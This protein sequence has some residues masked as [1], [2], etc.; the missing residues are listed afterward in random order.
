MH[1]NKET[2]QAFLASLLQSADIPYK[3]FNDKLL[4]SALPSIGLR[5]PFLRK[6]AKQIGKQHANAFLSVCGMTYH[7]ERLLYGFVCATFPY[8]DFLPHSD[9]FA[10][11][12]VENWAIC[13]TFCNSIAKTI[14]PHKQDYFAHIMQY[15]TSQN[16]WAVR[17][18]L[19]IMLSNYLEQ[20]TISQVLSR[21]CAITSD[22]YYVQMAQAWLLATAWAK[23]PTETNAHIQQSAL[24]IDV[25]QKFVQKARESKRVSKED[26]EN[27][28]A[29]LLH[30]KQQQ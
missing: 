1:W 26:K 4:A 22:F 9:H 15:L 8:A 18:G 30:K 11:H 19:V 25:L 2:Y 23:F 12:L 3:Q 21:T 28:K 27:L 5:L 14:A 17:T 29:F 24:S 16:P 6:T 20:D 10:E 7:E 13:D